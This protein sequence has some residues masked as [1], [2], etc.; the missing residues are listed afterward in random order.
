MDN[1]VIDLIINSFQDENLQSELR[2]Q[3]NSIECLLDR[4]LESYNSDNDFKNK[5]KAKSVS[6]IKTSGSLFEKIKRN[7]YLSEEMKI[8]NSNDAIKFLKNN[9]NDLIGFR[10]NCYF[11]DDEEIVFDRLINDLRENKF[12][13]FPDG[14]PQ[15]NGH[16][17]YKMHC[18]KTEDDFK[19]EIQVKSLLHEVWGEV[20]HRLIYKAR[21][22]DTSS[23]LQKDIIESLWEIL[24]GTD[25]QLIK[26]SQKMVQKDS[27]KKE[28]FYIITS[29]GQNDEILATHYSNFFKLTE[30]VHD[31]IDSL[32]NYLGYYLLKQDGFKPKN[33]K[34]SLNDY[35]DFIMNKVNTYKLE[36]VCEI[37]KKIYDFDESNQFI[38]FLLNE[39]D[40][41]TAN[42]NLSGDD[43]GDNFGDELA[44]ESSEKENIE[45]IFSNALEVILLEVKTN[46]L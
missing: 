22:Y 28:L 11:K 4:I 24:E 15:K 7:N 33:I 35:T 44:Y 21:E 12:Q 46:E 39:I 30:K 34:A 8:S 41:K 6:R 37:A 20:E 36:K 13:V 10:I 40:S 29:E 19:F 25:K 26:M 2:N 14:K 3:R 23:N 38:S 45:Q 42:D 1:H 32:D 18:Y 5:I 17:I 9:V 31:F 27:T 16:K 43:F